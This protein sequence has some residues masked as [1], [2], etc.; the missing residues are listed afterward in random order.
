MNPRDLVLAD[1]DGDAH[2]D[3]AVV[4]EHASSWAGAIDGEVQRSAGVYFRCVTTPGGT[5]EKKFV[6]LRNR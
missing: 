4:G 1:P 2:L 6:V 5:I 3:L